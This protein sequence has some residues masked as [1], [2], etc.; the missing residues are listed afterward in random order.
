MIIQK[1]QYIPAGNEWVFTFFDT[2]FHSKYGMEKNEDLFWSI[3]SIQK[4]LE[5][6]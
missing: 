2:D 5:I 6:R 3:V 4:Q 1:I